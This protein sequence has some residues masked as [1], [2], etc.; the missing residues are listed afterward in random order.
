MK[1]LLILLTVF[2]SS[3]SFGQF[4][5]KTGDSGLDTELNLINTEAKNDLGAFKANITLDYGIIGEKVDELLEIMM[6]GEVELLGRI[7]DL[8]GISV[9]TVV[10]SYQANKDKGWGAIAKDLGIKPGSAE[11]HALKGKSKGGKGN[12]GNNGNGHSKGKAK[13]K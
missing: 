12:S 10:D 11:F 1:T 3:I 2:A 8:L 6:P 5:F 4:E 9:D 7:K 13:N